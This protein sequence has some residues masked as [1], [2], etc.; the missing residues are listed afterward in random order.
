MLG[1]V[2]AGPTDPNDQISVNFQFYAGLKVPEFGLCIQVCMCTYV[3]ATELPNPGC[4]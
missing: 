2:I 4:S 1:A 3:D